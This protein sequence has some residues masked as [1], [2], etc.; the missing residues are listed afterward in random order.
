M[1]QLFLPIV[2][3]ILFVS[4]SQ[5]EPVDFPDPNLEAAIRLRLGFNANQQIHAQHLKKI[6]KLYAARS[7]IS[8]LS[9]LENLTNLKELRLQNNKISDLTAVIRIDQTGMVKPQ[10]KSD[11]RYSTNYKTK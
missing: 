8:N 4:C 5:P 11:Q 2:F 3:L 1:K 9:G 6:T 10:L 7:E